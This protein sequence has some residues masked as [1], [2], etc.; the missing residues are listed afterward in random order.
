MENALGI[1]VAIVA[2]M[3]LAGCG[4]STGPE[5]GT[6]SVTISGDTSFSLEGEALFGVST[7]QGRDH[8]VIFLSRGLF[9]GL[10]FDAVAIGRNHS[11]TPIGVSVHQIEDATSDSAAGEDIEAVYTLRR[12]DDGS[13]GSYASV[14]GTLTISSAT[15]EQV[16]GDFSFTADFVYSVGA[17]GGI[18]ELTLTGSFTAIPGNI[19]SVAQ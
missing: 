10:D 9:G 19:P 2:G 13:M 14:S 15:G 7:T 8:W 5:E 16:Q 12:S 17:F 1:T 11:A 18:R 6:F 3:L 4:G